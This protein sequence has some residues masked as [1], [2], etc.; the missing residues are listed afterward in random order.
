MTVRLATSAASAAATGGAEAASVQ[1]PSAEQ[2]LLAHIFGIPDGASLAELKKAH[3][4]RPG[5]LLAVAGGGG[6]GGTV[7]AL[8]LRARAPSL[9]PPAHVARARPLHVGHLL[10]SPFAVS[11][12]SFAFYGAT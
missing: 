7:G 11:L 6:S 12:L 5:L 8:A 9:P 1:M 10:R 4:Q 3:D 2:M